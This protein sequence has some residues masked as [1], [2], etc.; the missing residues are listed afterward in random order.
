M[1]V[2]DQVT[3]R[4]VPFHLLGE[5]NSGPTLVF[6]HANGYPPLA[7]RSL[8][9]ALAERYR[10]IAMP[11]R[12]LWQPPPAPSELSSWHLFAKDLT[13][14]VQDLDRP[15]VHIGH[16]IGAVT[17]LLAAARYPALFSSMIAIEPVLI[18]PRHLLPLR[19]QARMSPGRMSMVARTMRRTDRWQNRQTAFAQL[20]GRRV[21]E[22][23]SDQALRDH[24]E[25][26]TAELPTGEVALR[27]S[28][29]WE[30]QCYRRITDAWREIEACK[31]P[32]L[33]IR[34]S[35]SGTLTSRAWE[36]A[37]RLAVNADFVEVPA[38]SHLLPLEKPRELA[39][40]ICQWLDREQDA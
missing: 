13:R 12:P 26:A 24:I 39:G 27:Y 28:K 17:G 8:L 30:A 14:F 16:S 11:L 2:K 36:K 31:V 22:K 34:G 1:N 35:E 33:Y 37:R 15:V 21:F 19:I 38:T 10:L 25:S 3:Q 20:R 9:A 32:A 4:G 7:Y 40:L 18:E 23:F 6:T 29:E 5:I